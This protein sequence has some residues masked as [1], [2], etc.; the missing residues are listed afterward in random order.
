MFIA[1]RVVRLRDTDATGVLYFTEQ[2]RLALDVFEEF[3]TRSGLSLKAI[4]EHHDFLLPIVHAEA[5]F[6]HPFVV[7]DHLTIHLTSERLGNTSFSLDLLKGEGSAYADR[8][9]TGNQRLGAYRRRP[10]FQ[11]T[12]RRAAHLKNHCSRCG[13]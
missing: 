4:L 8:R 1:H 6:F 3:L 2:L 11:P 10:H 12:L 5:D 13:G 7:D 9:D